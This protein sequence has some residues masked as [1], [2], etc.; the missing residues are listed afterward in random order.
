MAAVLF[1]V[2]ELCIQFTVR[3]VPRFRAFV[4]PLAFVN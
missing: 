4:L 2:N 1:Q 3:L